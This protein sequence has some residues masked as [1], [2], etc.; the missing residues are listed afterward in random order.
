MNWIGDNL[1]NCNQLHILSNVQIKG[2]SEA[3][4]LSYEFFYISNMLYHFLVFFTDESLLDS[5]II[6]GDQLIWER[7]ANG[8]FNSNAEKDYIE[9]YLKCKCT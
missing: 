5:L 4:E 2:M 8:S 6:I 9:I 1:G 3:G 7:D